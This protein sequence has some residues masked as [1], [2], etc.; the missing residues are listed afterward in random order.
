LITGLLR[1]VSQI[2]LWLIDGGVAMGVYPAMSGTA[3]V[4]GSIF[5]LVVAEHSRGPLL[6]PL[7]GP[8]DGDPHEKL[9]A[10][11]IRLTM[12]CRRPL[13]RGSSSRVRYGATTC[14]RRDA[15][16]SRRPIVRSNRRFRA[17]GP[18]PMSSDNATVKKGDVTVRHRPSRFQNAFCHQA[19]THLNAARADAR[20]AAPN[21]RRLMFSAVAQS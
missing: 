8:L 7:P 14:I 19:T 6:I 4:F 3:V 20:A 10:V 12:D 21:L 2:P 11:L 9:S 13:V 17:R 5:T 15:T 16:M 1:S 18:G